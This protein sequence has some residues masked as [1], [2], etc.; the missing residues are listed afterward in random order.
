MKEFT[1]KI[2]SWDEVAQQGMIEGEDGS[3]YP[4]TAKEW[5]DQDQPEI[6][7]GVLVICRNGRD[8][9]EVEYLGIEHMPFL[10]ITTHSQDGQV[11]TFSRTRLVGG[12]W[13]MRSDA[14]AWMEVAKVIHSQVS[15]FEIEDISALLVGE[16]LPIS[17][18]G[19]VIKYCYGISIELYLKWILTEARISYRTDHQLLQLIGKLPAPVLAK[20]RSI[21]S[22]YLNGYNAEFKMM[23]ADKDGVEELELDWSTFDAFIGNLVKQKFIVGRYATPSEYSFFQSLSTQRSREMNSYMDSDNFFD[24]GERIL[25]YKPDP[26]DYE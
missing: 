9:S 16:H 22:E 24:L 1:G 17:L 26:S 15:H 3:V 25:A 21:Y 14:L 4:F 6:H 7:G 11:Q 12:P 5:K 18:R 19:S 10:K 2:Q 13:R 23:E 20:L 8:A